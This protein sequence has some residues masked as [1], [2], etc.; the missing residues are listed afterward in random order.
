MLQDQAGGMWSTLLHC[1]RKG[2]VMPQTYSSCNVCSSAYYLPEQG[3]SEAGV[4]LVQSTHQRRLPA[5]RGRLATRGIHVVTVVCLPP[6]PQH[7]HPM[8]VVFKVF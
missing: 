6:E 7:K 5:F 3:S 2:P 1:Q 8:P 4:V